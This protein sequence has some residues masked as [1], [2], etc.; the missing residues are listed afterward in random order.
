[1]K[2]ENQNINNIEM[3]EEEFEDSVRDI[4]NSDEYDNVIM[5]SMIE[6]Y[7][8]AGYQYA[9]KNISMSFDI[10]VKLPYDEI[11]ND[12][13]FFHFLYNNKEYRS[14]YNN[15]MSDVN[16]LIQQ[17]DIDENEGLDIASEEEYETIINNIC[18]YCARN[19]ID[20]YKDAIRAANRYR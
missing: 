17:S 15:A 11:C 1:M 6:F 10:N 19:A 13:Q 2:T 18:Y 4:F 7:Y 3:N 5:D 16:E 14:I 8:N 12:E 9:M 20:G